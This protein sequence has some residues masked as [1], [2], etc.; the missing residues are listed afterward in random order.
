M[1]ET[2]DYFSKKGI[3]REAV[4]TQGDP[5]TL[6][7]SMKPVFFDLVTAG[8]NSIISEV[9]NNVFLFFSIFYIIF[10]KS[11]KMIRGFY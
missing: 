10:Y 5:N 3:K 8:Y 1:Q 9:V 4:I 7:I 2:I 6:N 11:C